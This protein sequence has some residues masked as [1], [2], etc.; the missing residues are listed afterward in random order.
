LAS[1][2]RRP[3]AVGELLSVV[4]GDAVAFSVLGRD[5]DRHVGFGSMRRDPRK[6]GVLVIIRGVMEDGP[7]PGIL[8]SGGG[9]ALSAFG[10]LSDD[11]HAVL[12]VGDA[13]DDVDSSLG[14][15]PQLPPE[16]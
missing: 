14:Q 3:E 16:D 13:I 12:P 4:V 5:P 8:R 7:H 1:L 9:G 2:Q 15:A 11:A 10:I 6:V